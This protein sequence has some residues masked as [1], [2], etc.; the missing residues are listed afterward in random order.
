MNNLGHLYQAGRGVPQDYAQARQWH[1]KAAAAGEPRAMLNLGLIYRD[2]LGV[3]KDSA[4][5]HQ[6]IEKAAA[7]GDDW[8]FELLLEESGFAVPN[9]P[10]HFETVDSANKGLEAEH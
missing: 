1:R 6:W 3:T 5:A 8:A 4:Q 10:Q 9:A 7:A 2:G